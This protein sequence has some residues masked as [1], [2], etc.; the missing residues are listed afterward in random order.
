VY[1][2][3]LVD[4]IYTKVREDGQ[5]RSR[6]VLIATGVSKEGYREILGLQI[7]NSES[8]ASW[9]LLDTPVP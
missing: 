8:E 2:F 1:P 3:V 5:V 6:A 9:G 4:A 7:G